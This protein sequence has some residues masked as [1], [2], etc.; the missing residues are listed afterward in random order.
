MAIIKNCEDIEGFRQRIYESF[1]H[2]PDAIMELL[3]ALTSNQNARSVVELSLSAHFHRQYS[4]VFDAIDNYLFADNPDELTKARRVREAHLMAITAPHL[5]PPIMRHFWLFALDAT[6]IARQYAAT[7]ADKTYVYQP[8]S[9]A[10]NKPVTIGHKYETIVYLPDKGPFDPPWVVPMNIRRIASHESETQVAAELAANLFADQALPWVSSNDLVVTVGDG[11]YG[12][13]P[14]LSP[15]AQ[16]PNSVNATRIRANRVL[17]RLPK[18]V[19]PTK[20][21]RG[22]PRRYGERFSLKDQTTWGEPDEQ[23]ELSW[24]SSRG[25][26][27]RVVIQCW[28][29]LIMRG[30]Q[31]MPMHE[32]PLRLFNISIF[33]Q[34][35]EL[36]FKRPMWL[37]AIGDRRGELSLS[38][39]WQ[40]YK[41]RYD[42]E[43]FF[44]FG[45]QNLLM[46]DFETNEVEH[47][48]N[49]MS[50]VQLA[51]TQLFMAREIAISLPRPW[52]RYLPVKNISVV[53]PTQ[54]QRD[55]SR[56]IDEIGTP[57]KAPKVRGKSTGRKKCSIWNKKTRKPVIRKGKKRKKSQKPQA[58]A[59]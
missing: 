36:L 42:I 34:N 55:F 56:I 20:R 25:K 44:R 38:E 8:N 18:P 4:S 6:S 23:E 51:Y 40:A 32:N 57:A 9:I 59:A 19:D 54:T 17:Y 48:E 47:S 10:G 29:D 58:K 12:T 1:E 24:T 49:W 21:K 45:K 5:P 2:R 31:D 50:L 30:K 14:Y 41:Q 11:K 7:L 13:V 28:N 53:N 43:H 37:I 27:Y 35:G 3:D 26:S 15:L 16:Y 22:R 46:A 52:E 33:K 39:V